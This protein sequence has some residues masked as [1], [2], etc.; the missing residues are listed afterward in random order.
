M[1]ASKRLLEDVRANILVG[2]K[3]IGEMESTSLPQ[4]VPCQRCGRA[5]IPNDFEVCDT[6]VDE[7]DHN[8]EIDQQ[9]EQS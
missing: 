7:L 6:C 1:G 9:W 3:K 5:Y 8:M 4:L 2:G